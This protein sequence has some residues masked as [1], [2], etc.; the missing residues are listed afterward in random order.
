MEV[1]VVVVRV[2]SV[3]VGPAEFG[4]DWFS[5]SRYNILLCV[6]SSPSF[7]SFFFFETFECFPRLLRCSWGS[8]YLV[9]TAAAFVCV[10][11][12][13][14]VNAVKSFG[15]V[16]HIRSRLFFFFFLS[17]CWSSWTGKR[18]PFLL[19][20]LYLLSSFKHCY[21]SFRPQV[22]PYLFFVGGGG[23]QRR[24]TQTEILNWVTEKGGNCILLLLLLQIQLGL[25]WV[26][27]KSL[28]QTGGPH[29]LRWNVWFCSLEG[30]NS[31]R[32]LIKGGIYIFF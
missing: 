5:F 29:R 30:R 6:F 9:V 12:R 16:G 28:V 31:F 1:V 15:R 10:C 24:K 3:R 22:F 23:K 8:F 14:S 2:N 20:H 13:F 26:R 25:G 17:L 18:F 19:S 21:W 4:T 11:L 32:L 27:M 7:F